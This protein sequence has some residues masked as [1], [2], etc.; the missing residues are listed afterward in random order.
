MRWFREAYSPLEGPILAPLLLAF[1]AAPLLA[2]AVAILHEL[3]TGATG[4]P[5]PRILRAYLLYLFPFNLQFT[6]LIGVP[7]ALLW[8][9]LLRGPRALFVA[10]SGAGAAGFGVLVGLANAWLPLAL[11]GIANALAYVLLGDRLRPTAPRQAADR[12]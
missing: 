1:L 3:A 6:L 5:L 2:A 8:D 9:R 12:N 7:L 11:A 4:E 10:A